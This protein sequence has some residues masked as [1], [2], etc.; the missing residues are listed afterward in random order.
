MAAN[1]LPPGAIRRRTAFG[2]LDAD[3]WTWATIKAT[4][5]FLLVIFLLGY[6]P[7]RAYY[8]TVSPT[9]DLGFNAISPVNLC[10]ASN[11]TLPCPAT[12]GAVVPW[13]TSPSELALPAGRSSAATFA[14]GTNL[15]LVGGTSGGAATKSVLATSVAEGNFTAWQEGPPLPEAR[16]GAVVVS[17]SGTP[18]VL[19]GADASGAPTNTVWKGTLT[20]GAVTGWEDA[21]LTLPVALK[22]AAGISAGTSIYVFGGRTADGLS[23][24]TYRAALN[25][26]S[27]PKLQAFTE[28][29]EVPLPEARASATAV[30]LGVSAFVLG[31]EGPSGVT[32]SV[33]YLGLDSKGNPVVN[34]ATGRPFGWGV[35]AGPSASAALPEARAGQS[36]FTNGGAIYVIGGRDA[37]GAATTT[38]YWT[39]PNATNGTIASWQRLDATDLP[40]ARA[41]ASTAVV[42][43]AVFVIGGSDASGADQTGALRANLAPAAPFF[44][45]GLFGV[46]VPALSIKG[47]IGQQLGYIVAGSAALGNFVL[48]VLIGWA[49]SN[50]R[51]TFK[52]FQWIT[53]GRFRAP[54]EDDYTY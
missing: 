51:Q 46:T 26:G 54:P 39:V 15:Y 20:E 4:F 3:G 10:P 14:S 47:E 11:K 53:R 48:L 52:F 7:D 41:S 32:S 24:A 45:L 34:H 25:T 27:P 16:S 44:R 2:L 13:E 30:S 17:L 22:D 19:G 49:F 36:T 23:A 40:A 28:M 9:I 35:S 21:G 1:A 31:G 50:R 38:N 29:T 5:W 37:N 6:V 18:Y 42:G 33:F 43:S 12:P 8:L